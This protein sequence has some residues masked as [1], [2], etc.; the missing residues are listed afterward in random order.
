ME[1]KWNKT[2]DSLPELEDDAPFKESGKVLVSDGKSIHFAS[3]R[4]WD[5][6]YVV[7]DEGETKLREWVQD[8]R[9]GYTFEVD[10]VKFWCDIPDLP[11]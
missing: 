1:M 4:E 8:G 10:E 5:E 3:L 6:D 2:A 7:V 9:D 11:K